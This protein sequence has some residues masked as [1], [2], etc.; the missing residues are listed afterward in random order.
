MSACTGPTAATDTGDAS[1]TGED[2]SEG[3]SE[4]ESETGETGDP[5]VPTPGEDATIVAY[6]QA[7]VYFGDENH[8]QIDVVVE[9]PPA[10]LTYA[11][12]E[13]EIEL[14]CPNGKCDWWDRHGFL[15]VVIDP[16]SDQERIVELARFI[17]PY[18]VGAN[19]TIDVAA[20]RPLLAG[21]VTL[22]LFIDTWVGPGH[23][24]GDGW[25]V[26]AR[27]VLKGGVPERI[28]IAVIPAWYETTFE[29]GNP[30]IPTADSIAPVDVAIPAEATAVELRTLI[31]GHGQGNLDNCAEFCPKNH[32]FLIGDQ[33]YVKE[34]LRDD[35]AD[36]PVEGQQG[37]WQYSR[38]G[39][40]PGAEVLAWVEDVG[41]AMPAGATTTLRY[42]VEAYE[43][44][45]RPDA[46]ECTGCSLGT[47][48]EYDGGNHT[49]PVYKFS[50]VVVAFR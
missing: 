35:C 42:D 25:M 39:W 29:Y 15:G 2:E 8:R 36:T 6:E 30:M 21:E 19:W 14:S 1:E 16:G 49:A 50:S 18:R 20:L 38:A 34:I 5:Y 46:P 23:A 9:F 45:C 40:C 11:G 27:F 7:Y 41:A 43:N 24:N 10:E 4:A 3:G 31:T 28:P 26:D 44:S 12:A 17:T 13:L 32:G 47:G 48:C 33:S 22:R 37:T